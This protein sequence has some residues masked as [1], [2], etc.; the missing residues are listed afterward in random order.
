MSYV[1]YLEGQCGLGW[2]GTVSL[3]AGEKSRE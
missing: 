1:S 2:R 3:S